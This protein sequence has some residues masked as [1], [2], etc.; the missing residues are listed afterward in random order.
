MSD[1]LLDQ[2]KQFIAE[3]PASVREDQHF[4]VTEDVLRRLVEVAEIT[5]KDRVLEVGA[6]LGFITRELADKA[7]GVVVIEIDGRFGPALGSLPGNVVV[8]FGNAYKLLNDWSF[9]EK[10]MPID[11]VV[12]SIPYSQAQNMLHNYTNEK[13]YSGDLIW[14]APLS[15]IDKVNNE[16]ILGAFFQAEL[17]EEVPKTAFFPQPSTSSGIIRF[18]RVPNP[19][20]TGNFEVY[21]RRWLYSHEEWKV[22]NSLRE[23]FIAAAEELKKVKVTKKE[24]KRLVDSLGLT[25]EE[26]EGL[27]N[28]IRPECYFDIPRR[29]NDWFRKL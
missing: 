20:D 27:T 2:V 29:L 19:L 22:K 15:L 1:I 9:R 10:I 24:A 17:V 26:L 18:K 3:N 12:S 16:G 14:V 8:I 23:G 11:R 13:W 25:S 6:G 7:K 5:K 28:N 21:F 4:L